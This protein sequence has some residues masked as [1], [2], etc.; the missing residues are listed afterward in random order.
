MLFPISLVF[1]ALILSCVGT[2]LLL[3]TLRRRAV[4][5]LPNDR[6]SHSV[7]IPRGGGL[8]V[9]AAIAVTWL[10]W[11]LSTGQDIV[12]WGAPVVGA[13]GLAILSFADDIRSLPA[14]VRLSGHA[15]AVG[16]GLWATGGT[17]AFAAFLPPVLDLPITALAWLWFINLYNFMDGIDGIV[18]VETIA[19]GVGVS[20]LTVVAIA[21]ASFAIPSLLVASAT[22]GFL[23]WNWHPARIFLGDAGSVPVGYLIGFMLIAMA[24]NDTGNGTALAAAILLPLV[25]EIDATVTLARRLVQGKRPTEAHREHAY[26]RAVQ[27]GWSHARVCLLITGVNIVLIALATATST[28]QPVPAL[29]LGVGVTVVAIRFLSRIGQA[30]GRQA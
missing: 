2:W 25:F 5:D 13:I 9:V 14:S 10:I 1:A 26:Q 8:A 4:L 7:P 28:L 3:G 11:A 20:G 15:A 29:I 6:S 18:G 22:V 23:I 16:L 19:I 24:G 21:P 17:G 27:G 12:L 30:E